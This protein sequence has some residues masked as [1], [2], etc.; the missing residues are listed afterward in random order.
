M[1]AGGYELISRKYQVLHKK[2]DNAVTN[3]YKF[4][5]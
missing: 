5:F 2:L 3:I 4:I 1:G